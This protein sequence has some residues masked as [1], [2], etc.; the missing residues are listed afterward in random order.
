M[1]TSGNSSRDEMYK[2]RLSMLTLPSTPEVVMR[3]LAAVVAAALSLPAIVA[4]QVHDTLVVGD[5][6]RIRVGEARGYTNEF[7]GRLGALSH[8]TLTLEIP[9]G[10]GTMMFARSGIAEIA[11]PNGRE[12]RWT[13][14]GLVAP[15]LVGPILIA[16]SPSVSGSHH[17]AYRTRSIIMGAALL[18]Y[19]ISAM[20]RH[21]PKERW[22]PVYYWLDAK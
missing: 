13:N 14:A 16:T 15:L 12:S 2:R 6:V 8:D 10:K 20:L 9:R 19:P 17:N 21:Q 3:M 22:E 18:T 7:I 4:A 11:V 5:R 1:T